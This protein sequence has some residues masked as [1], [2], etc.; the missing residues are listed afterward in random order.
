MVYILTTNL[1]SFIKTKDVDKASKGQVKELLK[2][3]V[4][5][6]LVETNQCFNLKTTLY[7]HQ[8]I[9]MYSAYKVS[10]LNQF[11]H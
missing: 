8:A 11:L 2:L 4:N 3:K 9:L 6:K 7:S 10:V 1:L 5:K